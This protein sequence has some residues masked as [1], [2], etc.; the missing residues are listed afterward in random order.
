MCVMSCEFKVICYLI[1]RNSWGKKVITLILLGYLIWFTIYNGMPFWCC[2]YNA[3][4]EIHHKKGG[5]ILERGISNLVKLK[6]GNKIHTL[7]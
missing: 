1:L 3:R 2:S 5:I 7:T 6:D 4:D